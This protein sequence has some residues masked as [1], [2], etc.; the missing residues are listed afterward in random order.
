LIILRKPIA[1]LSEVALARFVAKAT[2]S[3]RLKGEV[4]VLVTNNGE[5]R[6]LNRSFRRMDKPTDVLSFPAAS[7]LSARLAGDV[8]ISAEIAA[9]N[10]QQLGH[11]T[12]QEIK[13]LALHGVLHLAGY[14]HERDHGEMAWK[15]QRLRRSLGLPVGL[16]ERSNQSQELLIAKNAKTAQRTLRKPGTTRVRT[17]S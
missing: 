12:A 4:N 15:E 8:A 1:G 16:I 7:D 11:S 5:L 13:I 17:R 6:R 2:R 9:R 14:D 10:A 3:V